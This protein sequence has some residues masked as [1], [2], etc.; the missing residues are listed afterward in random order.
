MLFQ[1][2]CGEALECVEHGQT[3][4]ETAARSALSVPSSILC[5]NTV[6][7]LGALECKRAA[8]MGSEDFFLPLGSVSLVGG[9]RQYS[10]L[11]VLFTRHK[12]IFI[13]FVVKKKKKKKIIFISSDLLVCREIVIGI[14]AKCQIALLGHT[15]TP[16]LPQ[17]LVFSLWTQAGSVKA[18]AGGV[19]L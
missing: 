4:Q 9:G 14:L 8:N 19:W 16:A 7:P 6:L 2:L 12:K 18:R 3:T 17:N 11:T 5:S 1:T 13:S 10:G 15:P